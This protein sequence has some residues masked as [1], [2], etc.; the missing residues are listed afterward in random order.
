MNLS[1][2]VIHVQEERFHDIDHMAFFIC[3]RF[4]RVHG[5][6]YQWILIQIFHLQMERIQFCGCR[7]VDKDGSFYSMQQN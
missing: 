6:H 2:R 3:S 1:N 5:Y 7:L 4:Q